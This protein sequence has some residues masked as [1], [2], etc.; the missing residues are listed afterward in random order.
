MTNT[1]KQLT[2]IEQHIIVDKWTEQAYTGALLEEHREWIFFCK[3]CEAP[4]YTSD[5][6]FDSGCGWPSFDDAIPGQVQEN[7]DADQHRVE[8]TCTTCHG[9][10]W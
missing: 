10:L 9:H 7:L 5:M 8:I 3:R 2:P 1:R 6:K 4:L